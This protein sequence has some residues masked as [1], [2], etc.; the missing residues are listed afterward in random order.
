M[1]RVAYAPDLVEEALLLAEPT[2]STVDRRAFRRERD[3][4]YEIADPERREA[5]FRSLHL[6]WFVRVG[7]PRAVDQIVSERPDLSDR[8]GECRVL[9]ALTRSEESADLFDRVVPDSADVQPLLALRLRP[10]TL[11][12][13]EA[14]RALL[15]HELTHVGDM[16]D[17]AFG[18][19]RSLP[20][21]DNGPADNIVR[22]RYRVL[23]DVTIDGR[24]ARAG[25][26]SDRARAARWQEFRVTFSMLGDHGCDAFDNWFDRIRP[27]HAALAAF[28]RAPTGTDR[29]NAADSGRCPL[30]RFPVTFLDRHPER[31]SPDGVAAI[32]ADHPTWSID[33]GLCSQCLDLY[34]AR[35]EATGDVRRR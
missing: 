29:S 21:S 23:W 25:L 27:T 7:L 26:G 3:R 4:I 34:E 32:R 33:R 15:R 1:I 9:R 5:S 30:C 31:L 12:E 35:H 17:P 11:L 8:V 22:D 2:W 14:V 19:Q 6:H 13:P 24:L 10:A 20:P 28:A 18:Y 16:L